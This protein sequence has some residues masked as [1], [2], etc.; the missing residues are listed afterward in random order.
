MHVLY[1]QSTLQATFMLFVRTNYLEKFILY[2]SRLILNEKRYKIWYTLLQLQ[3][4]S[5][6][7]FRKQDYVKTSIQDYLNPRLQDPWW[8][9]DAGLA[10]ST[11]LKWNILWAQSRTGIIRDWPLI[12]IQLSELPILIQLSELPI[13]I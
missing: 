8:L 11:F 6:L 10:Q 4:L 12:L 3:W 2:C 13:L 5:R 7:C 9:I 1:E